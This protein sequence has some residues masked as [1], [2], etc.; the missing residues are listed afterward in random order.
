MPAAP[1]VPNPS[2][3]AFSSVL[4]FSALCPVAERALLPPTLGGREG[5]REGGGESESKRERE[6]ERER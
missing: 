3:P 1:A 6:R 2:E 5:G 4:H